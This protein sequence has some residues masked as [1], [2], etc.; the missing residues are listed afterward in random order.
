MSGNSRPRKIRY[1]TAFMCIS[2]LGSLSGNSILISDA[3]AETAVE[4]M[5]LRLTSLEK[6]LEVV[7]SKLDA[8]IEMNVPVGTI[9][10]FGGSVE[11]IEKLKA[12]GWLLCDGAKVERRQYVELYNAIEFA[13]GKPDENSFNLPDLRG[14]FVRGVSG[15]PRNEKDDVAIR[16][17]GAD[18][19]TAS[20]KGGNE[21]NAVGSLQPDQFGAHDHDMGA[22]LGSGAR[23]YSG[24]KWGNPNRKTS[25]TGGS[26]TRPKNIY[27][28]WII[29]ARMTAP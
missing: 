16:D 28:N 29:K 20:N 26:E 10:P 1:L 14:R 19:R 9:M 8:S 5:Q 2:L 15:E 12:K 18:S 7:E 13:F 23:Y 25:R 21:K 27:V 4:K 3:E 11:E 17:P 6:K 22:S 24:G